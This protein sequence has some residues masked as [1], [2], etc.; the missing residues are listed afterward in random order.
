MICQICNFQGEGKK[1]S[2]HLQS[3]HKISSKQYTI[4][5]LL[6]G[7]QPKCEVCN[8]ETRYVAFSF[9]R[10][11]KACSRK[12]SSIAGKEGGS[13][14][15]WNKGKT[16]KTD[17]RLLRQ[18]ENMKGERNPFFGKHHSDVSLDKMRFSKIVSFEDFDLRIKS[19]SKDFELITEYDDYFSRQKQYL[20]F[21]CKQC[22]TI[23]KKTLQAYERGSLCVVCH[24][25]GTSQAE[26]EIGEYIQSLGQEVE[27]NNRSILHPKE[28]D[29]F[30]PEKKF[31]I[32]HNGLYYH[33][34]LNGESKSRY[35]YL[36]KKRTA[37]TLGINLIHI[38]GDEWISK[39]EICK[40]MIKN[41][42]NLI[43]KKIFARKCNIQEVNVREAKIFFESNHISGYSASLSRWGLYYDNELVLCLSVRKPRQKKYKSLIEI[44]RFASARNTNVVGGLTKLL[45][46]VEFWAKDNGF[47]GILTYADLRF[48]D[49]N[50]Y[51]KSGFNLMGETGPDYWYTNGQLRFDRFKFKSSNGKTEK[52]KVLE[53]KLFK[54]YGC[55]S[56]IFIK[57]F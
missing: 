35:Y 22:N 6:G 10:F 57:N 8:G 13:A 42:L 36:N 51:L 50:G 29:V 27:F 2:N 12:G 47:K 56:N 49:G 28:I 26:K 14:P 39:K 20:E 24:P 38:F 17:K 43:D 1:F 32:E 41:R 31:G 19:R 55:G 25:V 52:Q 3:F 48:G 15:A 16:K 54:I 21:K 5:Y 7:N 34:I 11:C 40:S 30:V 4:D 37:Q 46:K 23:F 33:A 9:K 18:S 53:N 44:S 45:K